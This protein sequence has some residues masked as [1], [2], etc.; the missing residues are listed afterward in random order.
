MADIGDEV[1]TLQEQLEAKQAI[2][3]KLDSVRQAWNEYVNAKPVIKQFVEHVYDP[4]T[5]T[6]NADV[7]PYLTGQEK[8]KIRGLYD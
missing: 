1:L 2:K 8:V 5:D 4:A 6:F 3:T 7:E